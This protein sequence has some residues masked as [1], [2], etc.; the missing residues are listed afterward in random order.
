MT[1]ALTRFDAMAYFADADGQAELLADA[2]DSRDAAYITTALRTVVR[3]R[4]VAQVARDTGLTRQQLSRLLG[5][6]GHSPARRPPEADLGS[7]PSH[8]HRS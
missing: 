5:E 2:F 6:G 8:H 1:P 4:G 3:A 7:G